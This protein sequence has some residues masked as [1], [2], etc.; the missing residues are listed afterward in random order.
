MRLQ[1]Y[2]SNHFLLSSI[3]QKISDW[4][5]YYSVLLSAT[6][7]SLSKYGYI[8]SAYLHHQKDLSDLKW[9]HLWP[10]FAC[11]MTLNLHTKNT[12]L[13]PP[14]L[15]SMF[16]RCFIISINQIICDEKLAVSFWLLSNVYL[17]CVFHVCPE[18]NLCHCCWNVSFFGDRKSATI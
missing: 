11:Y 16:N 17:F 8:L 9:N 12:G 5:H 14:P 6:V 18:C 15:S 3:K 2:F 7:C 13:T 4:V 1:M 10:F